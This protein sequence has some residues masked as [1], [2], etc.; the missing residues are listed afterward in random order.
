MKEFHAATDLLS[1]SFSFYRSGDLITLSASFLWVNEPAEVIRWGN[2]WL[3][4]ETVGLKL[5][6]NLSSLMVISRDKVT[7]T[8]LDSE[9]VLVPHQKR[10]SGPRSCVESRVRT[11]LFI[12]YDCNV[13]VTQPSL[14]KWR[15]ETMRVKE[16]CTSVDDMRFY[17]KLGINW[18][19]EVPSHDSLLMM[20]LEEA[21]IDLFVLHVM[22]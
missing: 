18:S 11:L 15:C 19:W 8:L 22:E 12:L 3:W 5:N 7:L 2:I 6:C 10:W 20:R 4:A 1:C 9:I 16:D 14:W 21:V 17:R 13:S